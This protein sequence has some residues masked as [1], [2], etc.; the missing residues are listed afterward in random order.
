MRK[1]ITAKDIAREAGVSEA[2]VSYIV[3]NRTDLKIS[4]ATRK[5]VLQLCNLFGY[6]PSPIA[7][8]LATG[9]FK[10]VG[11]Q[12]DVSDDSLT[13]RLQTLELAHA[14]QTALQ[15]ENYTSILMPAVTGDTQ[16]YLQ[17]NIDGIVCLNLSEEAFFI[18]KENY[19][20][21]IVLVDMQFDDP[22]F[23]KVYTDF[24]SVLTKAK[25]LL[26]TAHVTY[27]CEPY[28]NRSYMEE[29]TA[30][31]SASQDS[32][33]V[34]PSIPALIAYLTEHPTDAYLFDHEALIPYV[35]S[36]LPT[37]HYTVIASTSPSEDAKHPYGLLPSTIP[38]ILLP[39]TDKATQATTIVLSAI[40]RKEGI[41]HII[42]CQAK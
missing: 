9:K 26:Q 39:V 14:L 11:I 30:S 12:F 3:N 20:I 38:P 13:H 15:K 41:P 16:P 10:S 37:A 22:L 34:A 42:K 21:P 29:L 1:R 2:T 19:Y 7:Q 17:K 35:S 8:S 6:T 5:R 24:S 40:D 27:V 25:S 32:L 28:R 23:Y 33:F 4:D 36:V 31:L 18:L